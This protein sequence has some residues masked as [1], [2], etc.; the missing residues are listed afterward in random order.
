MIGVWATIAEAWQEVRVHRGRI[1]LA[2]SGVSLAVAVLC[3]VF[4]M[5]Q[6][7]STMAKAQ[8]EA[9]GGRAATI[10]IQAAPTASS[11]TEVTASFAS[12]VERYEVTYSSTELSSQVSFQ[13]PDGTR[14]I[15]SSIVDGEYNMV[16]SIPLAQGNWFSETDKLRAAPAVI[17][18]ESMY[19]LL[20]SPAL[21]TN[22][23]ITITAPRQLAGVMV[24]VTKEQYFGEAPKAFLIQSQIDK[25]FPISQSNQYATL[26][27]WVPEDQA[28][29]LAEQ[30]RSELAASNPGQM[31][32]RSDYGAFGDPLLGLQI[33]V[34]A[35]GVL[36][37]LLGALG[38]LNINLVTIK[39]RVAEIGV[40]RS[41]GATTGRIFAGIILESVVATFLAGVVGVVFV[42][43][44]Y[45]SPLLSTILG[46]TA[47]VFPAF[48]VEAAL[49]G[50]LSAT[51]VGALA[52][53]VPALYAVRAKVI[54]AIRI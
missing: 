27:L 41:F 54:D 35:I 32:N 12:I 25:L 16:Q 4:A 34:T 17:V 53:L 11:A 22:P 51:V 46:P 40:R 52:G 20:G 15:Q 42:V 48:P 5:G 6:V 18:N 23:G 36:V 2:L 39:Y 43:L 29:V 9:Q 30:I 47:P 13:F 50:V 8:F 33:M 3:A 49:V 14:S 38:L 21:D 19:A 44:L 7:S 45:K 37:L 28:N 1:I 24:G 10:Q 31:V 26:R